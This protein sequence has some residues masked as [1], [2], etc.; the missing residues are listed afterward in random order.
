MGLAHDRVHSPAVLEV[1]PKYISVEIAVSDSSARRGPRCALLDLQFD[2]HRCSVLPPHREV[3]FPQCGVGGLTIE[4][5]CAGTLPGTLHRSDVLSAQV[6]LR[7][8]RGVT[9]P[10]ALGESM[11]QKQPLIRVTVSLDSGDYAELGALSEQTDISR[12]WLIRQAIKDLL[13]RCRNR[14]QLE[15]PL[16]LAQR[17]GR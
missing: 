4:S 7:T 17:R 13:E 1:R 16:W 14:E 8:T 10:D 3:V 12:S 9:Q 11:S 6:R 15:L 5:Y 2:E